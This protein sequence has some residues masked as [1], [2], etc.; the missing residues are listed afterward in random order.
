[1]TTP[2][3]PSN[4]EQRLC[5]CGAPTS[6]YL[7]GQCASDLKALLAKFPEWL[8]DLEVTVTRQD[9]LDG[10]GPALAAMKSSRLW[11]EG[12]HEQPETN[13]RL[14]RALDKAAGLL[15]VDTE[16]NE[17]PD[18]YVR[19]PGNAPSLRASLGRFTLPATSWP[20]APDAANLLGSARGQIAMWS[21][22]L[23]ARKGGHRLDLDVANVG[24]ACWG[25]CSHRSCMVIKADRSVGQDLRSILWLM[26]AGPLIQR[27]PDAAEIFGDFE[28]LA[29]D[30]AAARDRREPDLFA[31][32]CDAP[33]VR[34][35]I[36]AGTT[37]SPHVSTCGAKLYY[38]LE[39][40]EVKCRACGAV[41]D[42]AERKAFLVESMTEVCARPQTIANAL[43][44]LDMKVT[45]ASINLWVHRAKV[46]REKGKRPEPGDFY[47]VETDR[48]PR[49]LDLIV[50][51]P[52]C[53]ECKP[54]YLIGD[55]VARVEIARHTAK[56]RQAEKAVNRRQWEKAS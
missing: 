47:Q 26:R 9:R 10:T 33:D 52:E 49:H 28:A 40:T 25:P 15:W 5:R 23:A 8:R 45:A 21:E 51:P 20:F 13:D 16:G 34:V 19:T 6:D 55:V 12:L 22:R 43:S 35:D 31:G 1:V 3:R 4:P 18:R 53:K 37:V 27:D 39:D 7:C 24:P 11:D 48:C 17:I 14:A 50:V 54:M 29:V 56:L 2:R 30:L 41:Y 44:D 36:V 38:R 46:R 32:P 42:V